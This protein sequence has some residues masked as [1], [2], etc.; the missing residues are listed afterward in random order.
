MTVT[1]FLTSV[2]NLYSFPIG[3]KTQIAKIQIYETVKIKMISSI[4][5]D[6]TFVMFTV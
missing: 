5:E 6:I 2:I 3:L 4:S 1:Q